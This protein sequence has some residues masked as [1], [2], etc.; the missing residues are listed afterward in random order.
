[1]I[2]KAVIDRVEDG[3]ATISIKDK[4]T[5]YEIE[6]SQ[7]PTG[8][9]EGDWLLV[10]IDGSKIGKIELDKEETIAVEKRIREKRARLNTNKSKYKK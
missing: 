7:L 6:K 9:I 10:E 1:M 8:A 3:I 2:I 4:G 5:E